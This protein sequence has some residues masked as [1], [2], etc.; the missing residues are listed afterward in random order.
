MN[1][2]ADLETHALVIATAEDTP[3]ETVLV[4]QQLVELGHVA[5]FALAHTYGRVALVVRVEYVT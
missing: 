2:V 1:D 4:A 5:S 3:A